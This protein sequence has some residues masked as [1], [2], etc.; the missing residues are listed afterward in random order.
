[1]V[2]LTFYPV[3][4]LNAKSVEDFFKAVGVFELIKSG[5]VAQVDQLWMNDQ[6]CDL[7]CEKIKENLRKDKRFR[8]HSGHFID[9][10]AAMDWLNYSPVSA[11]EVP[12]DELWVW[13][14]D[15]VMDAME[16][17]RERCKERRTR[18]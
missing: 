7:L 10:S 5:E 11:F 1:M 15:E 14:K 18:A 6:Q 8:H 17:H 3:A 16:A 9:T 2:K 12:A 13:T 4:I